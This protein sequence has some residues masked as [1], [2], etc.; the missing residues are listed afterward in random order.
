MMTETMEQYPTVPASRLF[1]MAKE[2]GYEGKS[3]GHFRRIV[4]KHRPRRKSSE[5]YLRLKTLPGEQGQ[6]DWGHFGKIAIGLA[7]RMLMAFVLVLSFSRYIFPALLRK[8]EVAGVPPGASR[9]IRDAGRRSARA[10]LRQSQ[11][12]R[13]RAGRAS[14]PVSPTITRIRQTLSLPAAPGRGGAGQ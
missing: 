3:E 8:P 13:A 1:A 9:S 4:A 10:P 14:G 11:D 5:A 7:Q 6:V 2:R 12:D